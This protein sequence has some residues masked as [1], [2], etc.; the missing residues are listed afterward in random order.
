MTQYARMKTIQLAVLSV[1]LLGAT[2]S[3]AQEKGSLG[4]SVPVGGTKLNAPAPKRTDLVIDEVVWV[5][6]APRHPP[7]LASAMRNP[8]GATTTVLESPRLKITL[9]NAGT[10]RWASSGKVAVRVRLG[11]PDELDGRSGHSSGG[12]SVVPAPT[13]AFLVE[14]KVSA[15][16]FSG[17][18]SIPGSLAPGEKKTIE[19]K[20]EGKGKGDARKRLLMDVDKYYTANV[21]L[22]VKGDDQ[23]KNNGADLVFR[24][25]GAGQA[26]EPRLKQRVTDP[27]KAG[28]VEV[29][30]P[31][32]K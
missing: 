3:M 29:K 23:V 28:T 21:D 18:A 5:Y 24:V 7:M 10:E 32:G 16:P 17:G 15:Q 9:R 19:V 22:G 14:N 26:L 20:L 6:V 27:A 2:T 8:P 4:S 31:P 25:N 1:A 11:A 13:S 12:V 30:A